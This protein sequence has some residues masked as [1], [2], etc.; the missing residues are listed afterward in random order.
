MSRFQLQ[1]GLIT[2]YKEMFDIAIALTQTEFPGDR[3]SK[4]AAKHVEQLRARNAGGLH[5]PD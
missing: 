1:G 2:H 4:I 3:I 5:L